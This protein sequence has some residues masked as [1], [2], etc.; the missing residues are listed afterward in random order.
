MKRGR[1]DK[2][3]RGLGGHLLPLAH[4]SK[5]GCVVISSLGRMTG[6]LSEAS[7]PQ[8]QERR[9]RL[10]EERRER[11]ARK[12]QKTAAAQAKLK[13]DRRAEQL[14]RE[15]SLQAPPHPPHF[16]HLVEACCTLFPLP[17]RPLSATSLGFSPVADA[18]P[19]FR[20]FLRCCRLLGSLQVRAE[21]QRIAAEVRAAAEVKDAQERS[22]R[23]EERLREADNRRLQHLETIKE[24]ATLSK[25]PPL[26]LL[27]CDA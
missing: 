22:D 25:V 27:P 17:S 12:E 20:L 6:G 3:G 16:H 8:A 7:A 2:G 14:A 19:G 4:V 18:V 10:E 15:A 1:S 11:L 9:H 21:Q 24:R 5:M 26:L 23:L 13:E